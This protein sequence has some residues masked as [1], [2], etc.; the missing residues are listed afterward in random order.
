[1]AGCRDGSAGT[2]MPECLAASPLR[3][4]SRRRRCPSARTPWS[5][6]YDRPLRFGQ[7]IPLSIDFRL[8]AV[9][10][11][12]IVMMLGSIGEEAKGGSG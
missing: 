8:R 11:Y 6:H 7:T 1:M 3:G 10:R 5:H 12:E 9:K 4:R 2:S